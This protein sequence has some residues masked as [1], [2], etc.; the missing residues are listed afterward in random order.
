MDLLLFFN[1]FI[2]FNFVFIS[3]TVN[4]SRYNPHKQELFGVP[5]TFLKGKGILRSKIWELLI[6]RIPP[7]QS[8]PPP[9]N[10]REVIAH[11]P[12]HLHGQKPPCKGRWALR[13]QGPVFQPA[14]PIR[15]LFPVTPLLPWL[16][17]PPNAPAVEEATAAPSSFSP[18][19]TGREWGAPSCEEPPPVRGPAHE[20]SQG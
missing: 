14:V 12:G 10:L 4:T 16:W 2:F 13:E 3:N 9:M 11:F 5:N 8:T 19:G 20:P 1:G 6:H 15:T 7:T 17:F 18:S